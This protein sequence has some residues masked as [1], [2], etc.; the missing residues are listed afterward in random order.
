MRELRLTAMPAGAI[1]ATR[2]ILGHPA[3]R[4]NNEQPLERYT[5]L[6]PT[7][8]SVSRDS[9]TQRG[10]ISG[11]RC[12][13]TGHDHDVSGGSYPF[14]AVNVYTVM[15]VRTTKNTGCIA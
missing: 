12:M 1:I 2:P 14:L 4:M 6:L 15:R 7:L 3:L 8:S 13:L 9:D 11:N 10:L 5:L